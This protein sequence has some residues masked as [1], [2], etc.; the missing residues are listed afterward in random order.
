MLLSRAAQTNAWA[1]VMAAASLLSP[2]GATV[3][4]LVAEKV[5]GDEGDGAGVV[6]VVS[7]DDVGSGD[8]VAGPDD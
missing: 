3:G 4:T 7:T 2:V 8:S 6:A 5:M 1:D